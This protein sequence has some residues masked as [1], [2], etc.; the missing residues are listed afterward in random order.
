MPVPVVS[1]LKFPTAIRLVAMVAAGAL[2]GAPVALAQQASPSPALPMPATPPDGELSV[3]GDR[4]LSAD[5]RG[6]DQNGEILVVARRIKGQVEADQPPILTLDED[7]IAAYGVS[8]LQGLV[9]ALVPQTGTGRG[10]GDGGPVFLVNGMRVA[11]FREIRGLPPEAI[12]RVEVLPEEVALKFGFRP[13][14]RVVNF[15]LKDQFRGAFGEV[16][17]DAPARGGYSDWRGE[18]N[19]V[20]IAKGTRINVNGEYE[21]KT[22]ETERARGIIL[23]TPAPGD[24]SA[25]DPT[26]F[27]TLLP[28]TTT[29]SINATVA[30]PLGTGAGLTIN[31]LL[32]RDSSDALNGLRPTDSTVALLSATRTTTASVGL[33]LN[34]PTRGWLLSA[35]LDGNHAASASAIDRATAV[36]PQLSGTTTDSVATLVTMAGS[37][38]H[39]P[40]GDIALTVKAG[41][42]LSQ[43]AGHQSA[44]GDGLGMGM[45]SLPPAATRMRRGEAQA[46]FSLDL[47][48]TSAKNHVAGALG[49]LSLNVNAEVHALSDFG[50]LVDLG[51]GLTWKPT[52]RWTL[53]ATS[54]GTQAAPG[55]SS[56]AAPNTATPGVA[57]F[58]FVQATT[59]L[60]TVIAGGNPNLRREQ[61]HDLKFAS[62]WTLPFGGGND[63]LVVEY[64]RN[65]SDNSS[66]AFPPLTSAVQQA[67]AGRITRGAQNQIIAIDETPI[68][69]AMTRSSR[70]RTTINLGGTLGKPDPA[71][72]QRRGGPG[73]F[74][75]AGR[76]PGGFGGPGSGR[77]GGPGGP[78]GGAP[79]GPGGPP[80]SDGRGRWNLSVSYSYELDNSAL[81]APGGAVF[82]QLR[83]DVLTGTGVAR[84]SAT[85]DGGAFYRGFGLRLNGTFAGPT[86]VNTGTSATAG[87][88]PL[89][90]GALAT[91]NAR[92]FADLGR[93]AG[94]VKR[95]PLTKGVR[96]ELSLNNLFDGQQ[97]VTDATGATPLRYQA[98]Y[99]DPTGRL[100]KLELR[101]QF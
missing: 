54:I 82:D 72:A 53:G 99:L 91:I 32:Q 52:S 60:A 59:V 33:G 7:A 78:G 87:P 51:V 65:H 90:F 40:A 85:L 55:L 62:Y 19:L 11:N 83:G 92:L 14:Q 49:D 41:Y 10:H 48:L 37:P 39:V 98:G 42:A 80:P 12:R 8:S 67:F 28:G 66:G 63:N 69:L 97:K 95:V 15:I 13:D 50:G 18:T 58:D 74:N 81:L 1:A 46:G 89:H 5:D 4:I 21:R 70:I 27:R 16:E 96:L 100:I 3:N 38:A 43:I 23:S 79:R 36:L 101:K 68:T 17:H 57:V 9:A 75:P 25:P 35:T 20:Q 61:Q 2:P 31:A 64:F 44:I 6:F 24:G 76:I 84:H 22:A 30:K 73:G 94:L 26:A 34:L 29:A 77:G 88:S 93:M 45:G 71:Q 86:R 47:P 56:L